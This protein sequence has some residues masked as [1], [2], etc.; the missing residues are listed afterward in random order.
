MAAPGLLL[1]TRLIKADATLKHSSKRIGYLLV[2]CSRK[3]D[4]E[5]MSGSASLSF[6]K[7]VRA[8]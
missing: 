8:G 2:E 3:T 7:K 4:L 6:E 1:H 5:V